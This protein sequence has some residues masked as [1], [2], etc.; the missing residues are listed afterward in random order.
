MLIIRRCNF[1]MRH[2]PGRGIV[3][4][5]MR[6]DAGWF[7]VSGCTSRVSRF[8]RT[9]LNPSLFDVNVEVIV[10]LPIPHKCYLVSVRRNG[11]HLLAARISSERCSLPLRQAGG[12]GSRQEPNVDCDNDKNR[13]GD[14]CLPGE[15]ARQ[16]RDRGRLDR[17]SVLTVFEEK[18]IVFPRRGA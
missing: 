15:P 18:I 13:C 5:L 17:R 4:E 16:F 6:N 9:I 2:S 3:P 12:S 1:N 10:V 11:R 7:A 14:Y 8:T